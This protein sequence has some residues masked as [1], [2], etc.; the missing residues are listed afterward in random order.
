MSANGRRRLLRAVLSLSLLGLRAIA[1]AQ[2]TTSTTD[3]QLQG[4]SQP[5]L[6]EVVVTGSRISRNGFTAP[7]PV[8]VI[9][10]E[11]FEQRAIPNVGDALNELPAFRA[12][13]TP[14]TQQLAGGNVGARLLDLRG[15]GPV[16]TLVLV[17]GRRFV[18]STPQGS[19][20]TNLIPSALIERVEVV[21]GGAS[22]A[23]GSD[24]VAGVVNFIMNRK[25]EGVKASA[26]YGSSERSDNESYT[27]SLAGGTGFLGDRG[28]IV[29]A[30]EFENDKGMGD[31]YTRSWCGQE[32]LNLGNSPAGTAGRPA[33]N[34]Q[35]NVHTA[36]FSQDGVINS[37]AAAFPLRGITF[38]HDGSTR[39]FQ[40][41]EIY[42]T[43]LNPLFMKGG[44]GQGE[45]AFIQGFRISVPV[46]RTTLYTHTDFNFTGS[47]HGGLDLSYG[48]VEG[49]VLSSEYRDNAGSV[50]NPNSFG[51][52]KTGNPYLPASL[53]AQMTAAN[54]KSFNL[55]RSFGD[56][57][58]ADANAVNKTF[59]VVASL[60]GNVND[61]WS[62]D[63]YYEYG[64]NNF[65]QDDTN[66]VDVLR[67][68]NAID[69]VRNS[70]G[71]I[72]CAINADASTANDDPGC[73]PFNPF[74][75]NNF[76]AAARAYV[77]PLGFQTTVSKQNVLSANIQGDLFKTWAGPVSLAA[78]LE[79][80]R[81]EIRGDADPISKA[82]GFFVLNGQ[83]VAGRVDVREGYVETN[84]PLAT[85]APFARTIELNGAV[86]R[87]HYSRSSPGVADTSVSVTT[88]KAGA[89]WEPVEAVRFRATRSRDIRA[90]NLFEL[91]GPRSTGLASLTDPTNG[92][93]SNPATVSGSNSTLVPEIADSWTAGVVLRPT[94][95]W[96]EN[97][98]MSVDYYDIK[99][100]QAIGTLG[101]Q[102]IVNRCFQGAT[103]FCSLIDRDP[104]S[105]EV[106]NVRDV[107]LNV[108]AQI[109]RG[110]D[111]EADYKVAL[112]ERSGQLD[113]RLLTTYVKDLITIDTAGSTQRAGLT[114]WR[115]GTQ[116][117]LPKY[118]IDTLTTWSKGPLSLSMHNRYVPPGKYNTAFVGPEDPGYSIY[119]TNSSNINHVAGRAYTDLSGQWALRKLAANGA[120]VVFASVNNVFNAEPPLAPSGSGNGNFILFDPVGRAY[121]LGVR[122]AF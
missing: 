18:A 28:H 71:Q 65:R 48:R 74:G 8:T 63:G 102:T 52:I 41:G 87:T 44:E 34:I 67:I 10:A 45:N 109:T 107:L 50:S 19:I 53:Q 104:V 46:K 90:P 49:N 85:M 101:A 106:V 15:L 69:A 22:A 108:N 9:G 3:A 33:N 13:A 112:G 7:T 73:A 98:Q 6:Q 72:V 78:G 2:N 39:P 81:D 40:Y 42:G 38:N 93:Q 37:P 111:F 114:G 96:L 36:T 62:W 61:N 68:R 59:R 117:G 27:S 70:S 11:R 100:G 32:W 23:Y 64:N 26:S 77:T 83:A 80:R 89:V 97:L 16:R 119:L 113:F 58:N 12:S 95:S 115:A 55:G 103:E 105:N 47:T 120:V 5:A 51:A 43:T 88:W 30:V 54:I 121:R 91:F 60:K 94:W 4:A 116:P 1:S 84:I 99:I 56:I 31:C 57:G 20:D 75:R 25:L 17:D 110:V 79:G 118:L 76:S 122:V 21:T 29:G 24:A 66:N 92:R 35:S 86:R 14:A 82:N